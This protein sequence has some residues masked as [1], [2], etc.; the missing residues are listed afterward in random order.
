MSGHP[1]M[2]PAPDLPAR[3]FP[4]P[5]VLHLSSAAG[6]GADRQVRDL[7]RGGA[8]R[9]YLWH[10]GAGLDVVEDI[11]AR[12]YFPL[13]ETTSHAAGDALAR[14]ARDA[15][16]G[17]VHLHTLDARSRARLTRL[18]ALTGLPFVATLH[19]LGFLDERAFDADGMPG[20]DPAWTRAVAAVLACA[21]AVIAPSEFIAGTARSQ[22]PGVSP[23]VIAPG[24]DAAAIAPRV[25]VPPPTYT[26]HAP[27]HVVA[28]V[29]AIGPHK[30]SGLLAP[31][32]DALAGSDV[33][34]VVIGYTD[35]QRTPGWS[36]PGRLWIHGAY[37]HATLPAW[38]AAYRV[39]AVLFPNRLPESFSYTLSETWAGGVPAIV[40]QDG[41]LGERVAR[42]GGG[43]VLPAGFAAADAARLLLRLFSAAGA[44]ERRRVQSQLQRPDPDRIPTL[45]AMNRAVDLLYARFAAPSPATPGVTTAEAGAGAAPAADPTA[46]LAPLLAANLDG[47]MFRPELMR[48][49]GELAAAREMLAAREFELANLRADLAAAKLWAEKSA[50]DIA[51]IRAWAAKLE[52]DIGTLNGALA[53]SQESAALFLRLPEPVR[54]LMLKRARRGRG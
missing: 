16:L 52:A 34:I 23:V 1:S 17:L 9:H 35:A 40:P 43:F 3:P 49:A 4:P 44:A 54:N 41:A 2:P 31:L 25:E 30:G 38:L 48:L 22:L 51:E 11:A 26:A 33:G 21:A 46:A 18:V 24:I 14:F 42:H 12:R 32:A 13:A 5:A 29:G 45:Q 37:E 53:R 10:T 6:G 39:Q 50:G 7:A 8:R 20:A 15:G 19:D 28:V 47:F 27:E 36:L